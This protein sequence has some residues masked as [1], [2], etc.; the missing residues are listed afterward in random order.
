MVWTD[1]RTVVGEVG[2][3]ANSTVFIVE[4]V[5]AEDSSRSDN[6]ALNGADFAAVSL[7][8]ISFF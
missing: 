3:C 8:A 4:K 6:Y 1:V 2:S 7:R 5:Q